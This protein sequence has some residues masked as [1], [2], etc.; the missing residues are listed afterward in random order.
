[1]VSI[2][3]SMALLGGIGRTKLWELCN[4]GEL[5]RVGVGRRTFVTAKSLHAYVERLRNAD[6]TESAEP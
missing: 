4:D 5:E 2:P 3:D 1:L 6:Q